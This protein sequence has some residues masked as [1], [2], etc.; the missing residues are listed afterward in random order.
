[1][2]S[3]IYKIVNDIN[4]KVYV[5][6]TT[7]ELNAR[8]RQHLT[9]A[10]RR[11]EEKRPLYNAI[12][13]YG[14]EHFSI[15]LIEE[16]DWAIES[17]RE[18][19]WIGYYKGYEDGYNATRGG[20]GKILYDYSLIEEYLKQG[21]T[22]KEIVN[23]LGCCVDVVYKVS[24]Q[25]NIPLNPDNLLEKNKIAVSQYD[26]DGNY[27]QS[28]ESYADA[29]RWLYSQGIIEKLTSGVRAHIGEVCNG[30]R[31]S[32]YKFKWKKVGD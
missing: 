18:Q 30:T 11:S 31:K 13:L 12:N 14:K 27:I 6:K 26:L 10:T 8:F 17:E 28:F 24:K 23:L 32:A 20:D 25:T 9:D 5:G 21:K 16:C 2:T 7:L 19:Y 1:M 3:K 29:A 22:T 4:D 15:E